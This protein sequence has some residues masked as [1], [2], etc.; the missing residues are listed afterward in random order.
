MVGPTI[1]SELFDILVRFR[2]HQYV[3]IGDIVKIYRQIMVKPEHRL[4]QCILW[5]TNPNETATTFCL[6]TVTY[7][8][9]SAPFLAIRSLQQ[10]SFEFEQIYPYA[11]AVIAHDFYVDDM[12]TGESTVEQLLETKTHVTN[13]LKTEG[14]ELTKFRSNATLG[15]NE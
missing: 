10:L 1:Q 8:V 4:H 11:A 2:Q 5:R 14:F 15:Q 7:G 3:L 9:A 12:I 13:I 6:N